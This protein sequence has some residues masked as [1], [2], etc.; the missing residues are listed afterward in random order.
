[1]SYLL[2]GKRSKELASVADANRLSFSQEDS[3][4]CTELPF[5]LFVQGTGHAAQNVMVGRLHG[6]TVGE[7]T[8]RGTANANGQLTTRYY[9]CDDDWSVREIN[10][11]E[12]YLLDGGSY[13]VGAEPELYTIELNSTGNDVT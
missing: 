7:P 11:S 2:P 13:H 10:P 9:V 5:T 6:M 3:V 12:G 4:G 1:M 8:L